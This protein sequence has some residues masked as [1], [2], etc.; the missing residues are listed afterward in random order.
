MGRRREE[1]LLDARLLFR[2]AGRAA[3]TDQA[4]EPGACVGVGDLAAIRRFAARGVRVATSLG[5]GGSLALLDHRRPWPLVGALAGVRAAG[6]DGRGEALLG[7][8]RDGVGAVTRP[9]LLVASPLVDLVHVR[10]DVGQ[11]LF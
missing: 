9:W 4:D 3:G 10:L 2:L 11:A 8:G 5:V 7:L 1:I 6:F